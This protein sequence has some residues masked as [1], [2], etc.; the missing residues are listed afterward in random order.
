MIL[1][2]PVDSHM[3]N[4]QVC[5]MTPKQPNDDSTETFRP[6]RLGKLDLS[7]STIEQKSFRSHT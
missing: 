2:H 6:I 3:C 4:L 7:Q 5:D 1:D